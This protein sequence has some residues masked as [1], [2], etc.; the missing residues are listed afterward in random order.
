[1]NNQLNNEVAW[2][3]LKDAYANFVKARMKFF[4]KSP[5][6]V[7]TLRRALDNPGERI[8]A[9]ETA[10]LLPIDQRQSLFFDLLTCASYCH[11]ATA[12][13]RDLILSLPREWVLQHIEDAA[14]PILQTGGYEEYQALLDL[15]FLLDQD[16]TRRLAT[17]ALNQSDPE[18]NEIA[19]DFLT[20]LDSEQNT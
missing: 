14:E 5:E 8:L 17:R 1:M 18:L 2:N 7:A 13:S 16:L 12:L 11:G 3:E 10:A 6:I 20:E 4:Q 19:S 15:Y 9:L